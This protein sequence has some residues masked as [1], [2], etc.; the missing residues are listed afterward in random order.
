MLKPF[1]LL[2][3][4][5]NEIEKNI[6]EDIN[7]DDLAAKYSISGGYL[8]R[9]FMVAF[10]QPIGTY[11]RSRKLAASIYDLLN[12][13]LNILY[14]ALEYGF[15]YEQSYIRAFKREFGI[16]PNELRKTRRFLKIKPPL[17][18]FDSNKLADGLFFG[19]D[20]VMI[21]H[22]HVIGKKH[23]MK[24]CDERVFAVDSVKV[25]NEMKPLIPNIINPNVLIN[26]STEAEEN[27]DYWYLMPSV[28]VKSLDKIPEGFDS[29]T[30]PASLCA[31][32]SFFVHRHNSKNDMLASDR[33]FSAINDFMDSDD[34]KYFLERK[35]INI[36]RFDLS[37]TD[38]FY[39]YWE[40]F[41]PVRIKTKNDI[42]EHSPGVIKTYKQEIPALRFIG[43]KFTE[44]EFSFKAVLAS[45]DDCC[46]HKMFDAIKEKLDKDS[47]TSYYGANSYI[48]LMKTN[49]EKI[50]EYRIGM[51]APKKT[52]V[53]QGYEAIDLPGS[54]L[55]VCQVYG[56]R[57]N[58]VNY[59]A[60]CRKK[61]LEEGIEI[62]NG[63]WF[64]QRFDWCDFFKEDKFGKRVL[65]YCYYSSSL[66][67]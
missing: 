3:D 37:S 21:P 4:I 7:E 39:G 23:K 5:L 19:P 41:S 38:G 56:K 31:R 30:F 59:E 63:G 61:L 26:I 24:C 29:F 51:L 35:K 52:A 53:P 1:D 25:F 62:K 45:L 44:T 11:I 33:M 15:G 10:D 43:K 55:N 50:S 16:T 20:I 40:W 18:L 42:P 67:T 22:F 32:F 49:G 6:K 58:I 27:A 2:E 57:D 54:T 60:D 65:E 8:R 9:L 28:Q 13:N 66:P 48:S 34:Q 12:T 17:H 36:D 64:F 46:F 47:K 14:I